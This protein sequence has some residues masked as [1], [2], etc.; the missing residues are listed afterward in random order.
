VDAICAIV[1]TVA[2]GVSEWFETLNT[3]SEER[4]IKIQTWYFKIVWWWFGWH[5]AWVFDWVWP[6]PR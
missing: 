5:H 6:Y 3:L 2:G 1:G 4:G